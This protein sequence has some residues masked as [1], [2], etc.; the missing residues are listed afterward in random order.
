VDTDH[1]VTATVLDQ[2]GD[3]SVGVDVHFDVTGDGVPA[4]TT[5]D[6]VT[7]AAGE[8]T[9]TFTNTEAATNSITGCIDENANQTCDVG[10]TADT[11]EKVWE[12]RVA[13][14]ISL[15]P[16]TATN[17]V[18]TNHTVTATV[19]DQV[20]DPV[21]G[22]A[23]LFDVDSE[24][25]P[26]PMSGSGITNASGIVTFTFTNSTAGVT[27]TVT[28]CM[29]TSPQNAVCDVDEET[30]TATKSWV[31]AE[32][33]PG[34]E[35]DPRNQIV[36]TPG[37]DVLEGTPGDDIICGLGGDD[38]L[39]GLGGDD[40]ILGGPG[41]DT[42]IGGPGDDILRGHAGR[43]VIRGGSGSDLLIGG[44]NRD[45][46]QGGGDDDILRGNAGNDILRGGGGND[47]LRGG[48]GRDAI[49]GAS[50]DDTL[51]GGGGN[52]DLRAGGGDDR[53][54]G[55]SGDDVLRGG[56]G[57]DLLNGGAGTDSCAGGPGSDVLV[58]CES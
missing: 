2:F 56:A 42:L 55:G 30:D 38:T 12:A 27:N 51:R 18:D 41:N 36:G 23:V 20:G 1:T 44:G 52:D 57:N 26:S 33:C 24:G 6:D 47:D 16:A 8:A 37:D 29:D 10:E 14:A 11:A 13:T 4:P 7:D 28:A 49:R 31:A 19:V 39:A 9:F 22:V 50:G 17:E 58:N 3:P 35:A 15:D 5:G 54:F 45:T 53:V 43:D 34:F 25:T 32:T 46:L 48:G 21:Q 40:L